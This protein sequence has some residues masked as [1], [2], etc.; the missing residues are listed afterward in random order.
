MKSY[1]NHRREKFFIFLKMALSNGRPRMLPYVKGATIVA[2][3]C[4]KVCLPN[5]IIGGFRLLPLA[6]AHGRRAAVRL[7]DCGANIEA[8]NTD[9]EM[10]LHLESR[11]GHEAAVRLL[12]ERG[13]TEDLFTAAILAQNSRALSRLCVSEVAS[14]TFYMRGS[15]SYRLTYAGRRLIFQPFL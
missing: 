7:L 2:F 12:C 11:K 4:K 13:A 9:E 14:R 1:G 15:V 5:R 6:A 8:N 10:V 3:C